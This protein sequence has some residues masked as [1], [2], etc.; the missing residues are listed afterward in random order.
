[1][2]IEGLTKLRKEMEERGNKELFCGFAESGLFY[3]EILHLQIKTLC[4]GDVFW[5]INMSCGFDD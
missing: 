4:Q 5:S 1:M 3:T 2:E